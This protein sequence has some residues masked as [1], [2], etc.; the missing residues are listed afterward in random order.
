MRWEGG[1]EVMEDFEAVAGVVVVVR[2]TG[3]VLR[4]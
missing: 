2:A 4:F 3:F 1:E